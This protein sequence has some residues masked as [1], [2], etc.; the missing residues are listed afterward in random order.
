M[1]KDEV[2]AMA[3]ELEELGPRT[4]TGKDEDICDRARLMLWQ[5]FEERTADEPR[6]DELKLPDEEES[7]GDPWNA[8]W[9]ACLSEVRRALGTED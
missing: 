3:I 7:D 8:G 2:R 1:T 5:L 4:I 9:N 6:T